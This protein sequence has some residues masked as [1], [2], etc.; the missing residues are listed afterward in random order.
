MAS[1]HKY[2]NRCNLCPNTCIC[3]STRKCKCSPKPDPLESALSTTSAMN[4]SLLLKLTQAQN[5]VSELEMENAVWDKHSLCQIIKERDQ[6][7]ARIA[8]LEAEG[9][10]QAR[11]RDYWRKEA[12]ELLEQRDSLQAQLK[13]SR[14]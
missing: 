1:I 5:R 4:H 8:E 11:F 9:K 14:E 3:T 10:E 7:E 2:C 12:E 6:A 13:A